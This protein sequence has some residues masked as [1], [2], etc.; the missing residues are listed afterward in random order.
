MQKKDL[1]LTMDT[2]AP[3]L[4]LGQ[5]IGRW[6]NFI[7]QEAYGG[8]VS[9]AYLEGLHLPNWLIEQMYV[10][11]LGSYVHPTF[12]Y[13]SCWNIVG[14]II[15]LV[16]RRFNPRRGE[17]FIFYLIWY[18]IGR[19]FIEGLRTDSLYL[20]G[21]LRSAQVVSIIAIAVGIILFVYRRTMIRP[22]VRYKDK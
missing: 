20:V 19:F 4:I 6:G 15:V 11:H 1:F 3:Y 14:L 16:L 13:E 18:S 2:I 21:E 5:S 10:E 8:E 12:L 9:R 22:A 7:N 17:L